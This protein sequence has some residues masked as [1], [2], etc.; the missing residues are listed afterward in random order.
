MIA[1]YQLFSYTKCMKN[2][3]NIKGFSLIELI[4]VALIINVLAGVAIVAYIGV[5]EKSRIATVTRSAS[6]SSSDLQMWLST[7]LSDQRHIIEIDTNL[8]G[9][10]GAGDLTNSELFT[11]GVANT[12]IHARTEILRETSPWFDRP[13]WN[14]EAV[15]PNG[16]INLTQPTT[17]Q[18]ILIAKE[19]N[20]YV[21]FEKIFF[22]N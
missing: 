11:A 4:I 12:Y 7:S 9:L 14:S 1:F 5:Q 3:L 16:T 21:V 2:I 17:N 10:I 20:G 8:D 15:P 18:L 13:M 19:K 6:T 22:S